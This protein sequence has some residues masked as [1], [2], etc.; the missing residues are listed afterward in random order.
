VARLFI[1]LAVV[2][3]LAQEVV[4][5]PVAQEVAAQVPIVILLLTQAPQEPQTRA[6]VVA[7]DGTHQVAPEVR[8]LLLL[9]TA[10]H[11]LL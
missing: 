2:V 3:V 10:I 11:L 8:V 9:D 4:Q 7:A 5:E 6:A 1:T